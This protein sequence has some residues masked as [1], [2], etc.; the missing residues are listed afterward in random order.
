MLQKASCLSSAVIPRFHPFRIIRGRRI[1]RHCG[2][3]WT[4]YF[5]PFPE[6]NLI[7]IRSRNVDHFHSEEKPLEFIFMQCIFILKTN[8][9]FLPWLR[10]GKKIESVLLLKFKTC[11]FKTSFVSLEPKTRH[12]LL[13]SFGNK[14]INRHY[15]FYANSIYS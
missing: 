2:L 1:W 9:G 11:E 3:F 6:I 4:L 5:H 8:C 7:Y 15:D 10:A 13:I 14:D 12:N